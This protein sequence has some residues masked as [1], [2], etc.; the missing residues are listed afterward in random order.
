MSRDDVIRIRVDTGRA[1]QDFLTLLDDQAAEGETR[2]PAKPRATAVYR[3]L[4]PYRLVEY[5][6]VD[7]SVGE[8]EGAYVGLPDGSIYSVGDE[9]PEAAV[10]DMVEGEISSL[11]PVYIYIVLADPV[12]PALIDGFLTK[13][14]DHVDLPLVGVFRNDDG[15]MAA[16]PYPGGHPGISPAMLMGALKETS[17]HLSKDQVI[18][19]FV[20]RSEC[21]DGRAFARISYAFAKHVVEF[22]SAAERDDFIAWSRL[23]CET[24]SDWSAIG[25]NEVFRPAVPARLPEAE[26]VVT[27]LAAPGTFAG[28]QAWR[29]FADG[30]LVDP[31]EAAAYWRHVKDVI[32]A[33]EIGASVVDGWMVRG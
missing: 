32:D 2:A 8:V 3:E 27:P 5:A 30:V 6:Y 31:G 21:P 17:R 13:L 22:R 25:F 9:I 12:H 19:R 26:V 15:A 18:N 10:D 11:P 28:G 1:V 14:A 23:L 29:A 20:A 24:I 4:A 7:G 33:S 16:W